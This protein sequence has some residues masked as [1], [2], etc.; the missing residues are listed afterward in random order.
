MDDPDPILL[1]YVFCSKSDL[2]FCL[3][4]EWHVNQQ[5]VGKEFKIDDKWQRMTAILHSDGHLRTE[6]DGE[7]EEGCQTSAPQQNITEWNRQL[8]FISLYVNR[9]SYYST[10]Y[11]YRYFQVLKNPSLY[12]R[13]FMFNFKHDYIYVLLCLIGSYKRIK[14]R[15]CRAFVLD[16]EITYNALMGTLSPIR[17]IHWLSCANK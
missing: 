8:L 1:T 13:C 7:T 16:G 15:P 14:L 5:E 2:F 4:S 10:K 11:Q 6:S 12:E 17:G 3:I 9:I